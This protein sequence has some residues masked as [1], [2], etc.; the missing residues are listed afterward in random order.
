MFWIH[1]AIGLW[2]KILSQCHSLA[3]HVHRTRHIRQL[4]KIKQ[5]KAVARIEDFQLL[6]R[7]TRLYMFTGVLYMTLEKGQGKT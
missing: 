6:T 2:F 5:A 1:S 7:R 4:Q 3:G